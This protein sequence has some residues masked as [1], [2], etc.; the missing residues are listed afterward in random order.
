[1]EQYRTL[2]PRHTI[3]SKMVKWALIILNRG[4]QMKVAL[5][6]V[7]LVICRP[8]WAEQS[9]HELTVYKTPT[10]GCCGKWVDHLNDSG[11]STSVVTA[12]D[13]SDIKLK[14][15]VHPRLQSCHTAV[16]SDGYVFEG[17]I[18]ALVVDAF[19]KEPPEDAIGL[20]VPSMPV[21]SPGMEMGNQFQPYDVLMIKRDGSVGTYATI[22]RPGQQY[23][24]ETTTVD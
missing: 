21:G 13:L 11:Y 5:T 20:T 7:L 18:P 3:E 2:H 12:N 14:H 19:L 9:A 17:H 10:C 1:M 23:F 4:Q 15:G 8:S 16:N 6:I 24:S 22:S